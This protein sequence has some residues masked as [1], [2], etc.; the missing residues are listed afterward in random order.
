[1]QSSAGRSPTTPLY[2]GLV[3]TLIAVVGY[4]WYVTRR[5]GSL[6]E[7]QNNL[8]DRNRRDSLQLLRI[9]NELNS[10]GMS[11]RDMLD[12]DPSDTG[13]KY[14][15]TAWQ[16]QFERMR[17]D[18]ED[19]FE[20]ERQVSPQDR[21]PDQQRYLQASL[22][23]FWDAMTRNFE[24]A[25]NG[26]EAEARA[27]IRLSLQARLAALSNAVA[28]L[29]VQNNEVEE[30]AAAQVS[31]IYDHVQRQAYIFLIAIQSSGGAFGSAKRTRSN[32]DLDSGIHT[33]LHLS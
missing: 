16:P 2:I 13:Q 19:A 12:V 5:I 31:Q 21:T 8:I 30:R 22:A 18:L 20:R 26:Q 23:Q 14:P 27:Q 9:Q 24:L 17:G 11:M 1:V 6:R 10:I 3:I 4:S 7:L 15:L 33:S 32:S 28:R 25:R 29:L